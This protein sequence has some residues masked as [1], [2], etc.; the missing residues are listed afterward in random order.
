MQA[1][2]EQAAL[3][4]RRNLRHARQRRRLQLAVGEHP[5]PARAFGDQH[6]AVGQEGDAPGLH[7]AEAEGA[8]P[9]RVAGAAH[10]LATGGRRAR[11]AW[12]LQR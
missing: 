4:G 10:D 6:P 2:V 9:H 5:E 11:P 1:D 7:Q 12:P 3:P 8:E